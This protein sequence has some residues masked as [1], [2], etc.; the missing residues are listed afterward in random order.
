MLSFS[1]SL[2]QNVS[3]SFLTFNT[4]GDI[5]PD[6]TNSVYT[7]LTLCETYERFWEMSF[8]PIQWKSKGSDVI[9]FKTLLKISAEE[10]KSRVSNTRVSK[11][12]RIWIFG[13]TI[14]LNGFSALFFIW[15]SLPLTH[16]LWHVKL[17]FLKCPQRLSKNSIWCKTNRQEI[18]W[19]VFSLILAGVKIQN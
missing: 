11:W 7:H 8:V 1:Y 3:I 13:H 12:Q 18:L 9:C 14:P 10:R 15:N 4:Q 16:V 2:P 6:N 5:S 19:K 17:R